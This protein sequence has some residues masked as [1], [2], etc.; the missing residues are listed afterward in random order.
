MSSASFS[1]DWNLSNAE[2][3]VAQE[4][5]EPA[6]QDGM[7]WNIEFSSSRLKPKLPKFLQE[8]EKQRAAEKAK[9]ESSAPLHSA[10]DSNNRK[11]STKSS[12][13][14]KSKSSPLSSNSPSSSS[15]RPHSSSPRSSK[16]S[17]AIK[18]P[19]F[20]V[21]SPRRVQ[22]SPVDS[23]PVALRSPKRVKSAGPSIGRKTRESPRSNR[24]AS[25]IRNT[26]IKKRS[27][28]LD[29]KYVSII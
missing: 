25:P 21:S 27:D 10:S 22:S 6:T 5:E 28:S 26:E 20:S 24:Y 18:Q 7:S 3:T 11:P 8:R 4:E 13:P 9:K 19:L 14:L 2:D 1:I 29:N 17:P 12:S 15:S 23:S 16:H